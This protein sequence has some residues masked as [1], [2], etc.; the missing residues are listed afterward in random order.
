MKTQNKITKS[1]LKYNKSHKG[2]KIKRREKMESEKTQ[3]KIKK[4]SLKYNKSHK[5][6]MKERKRVIN[7]Q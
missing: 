1:T 4:S 2:K 6:K 5:G 3:N 7:Q